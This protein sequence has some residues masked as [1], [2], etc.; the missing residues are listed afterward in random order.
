MEIWAA[1]EASVDKEELVSE[2]LPCCIRSADVAPDIDYRGLCL[3][4]HDIVCHICSKHILYPELERLGRPE[5]IYVLVI[6][7]KGESCF[8]TRESNPYEFRDDV[9]ELD[10]VG[11]EEFS[12]CRNIVEEITDREVS[13][14]RSCQFLGCKMLGISKVNLAAKF[15]FLPSGL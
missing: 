5:N 1:E 9:L 13:S 8:G 6:V 14:T 10:I 3:D 11:L 12:S 4:V 7:G 2:H 15:I